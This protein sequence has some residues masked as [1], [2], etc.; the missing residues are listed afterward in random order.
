MKFL[1][2]YKKGDP[3]YMSR[4]ECLA[5]DTTS[6]P[7]SVLCYAM[8]KVRLVFESEVCYFNVSFV[9]N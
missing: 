5:N 6:V 4:M 1:I 8:D 2:N 9:Q 3:V 7:K